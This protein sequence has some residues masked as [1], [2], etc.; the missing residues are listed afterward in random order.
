MTSPESNQDFQA[1]LEPVLDPAF[2]MALSYTG[3]REA[4]A[5]DLVQEAALKAFRGFHSFERG[6]NFKAWFFRILMNTAVSRYRKTSRRPLEVDIEDASP[7]P[8]LKEA[9]ARGLDVSGSDPART[10]IERIRLES[11]H[12]AIAELPEE[13]R[14]VCV[15]YFLEEFTY[16]EIAEVL[17]IPVGT[18]RS[19]L[20]R[21]R[22]ALQRRLLDIAVED[23]LVPGAPT[24]GA[25]A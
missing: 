24:P 20:H 19:R 11:I 7:A 4:D 18:V 23:G 10:F 9:K 6:T 16:P 5:E 13:F 25:D 15:L 2:G 1:L 14:Q 17:E 8:L 12:E 3:G 22:K 21:A